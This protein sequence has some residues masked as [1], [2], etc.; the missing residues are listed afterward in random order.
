[1]KY[2]R[3]E[4]NDIEPDTNG[5]QWAQNAK[6]LIA[7]NPELALP[8]HKT[9]LLKAAIQGTSIRVVLDE[10]DVAKARMSVTHEDDLPKA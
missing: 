5:E 7:N 4:P 10:K 6:A 9:D 8:E 3:G 2:V 1:M